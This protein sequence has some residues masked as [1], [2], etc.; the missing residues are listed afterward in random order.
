MNK[1]TEY[2]VA[3]LSCAKPASPLSGRFIHDSM[4]LNKVVTRARIDS[5]AHQRVVDTKKTTQKAM[6]HMNK[7]IRSMKNVPTEYVMQYDFLS[8]IR[9]IETK[10]K[11]KLEDFGSFIHI[12]IQRYVLYQKRRQHEKDNIPF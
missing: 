1:D 2:F 9:F 11:V 5:I 3:L 6:N 7:I 4:R 10:D 12:L 8:E